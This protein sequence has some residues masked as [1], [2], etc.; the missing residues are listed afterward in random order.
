M[1]LAVVL[2]ITYGAPPVSLAQSP[3]IYA[4]AMLA[5]RVDGPLFSKGKPR[6]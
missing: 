3:P 5:A 4:D 1:V 6:R 2:Q